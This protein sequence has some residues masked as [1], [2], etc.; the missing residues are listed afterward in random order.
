[1]DILLQDIVTNLV[2]GAVSAFIA[3]IIKTILNGFQNSGL[4]QRTEQRRASGRTIKKQ[5]LICAIAFPIFLATGIL[6]PAPLRAQTL[7]DVLLQSFKILCVLAALFL[8]LFE[9]GAFDAA[10]DYKPE[11]SF[12]VPAQES[13]RDHAEK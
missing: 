7:W 6:I 13:A 5:F 8:F 1:M 10:F 9:W 11:D 2:A 12:G 3:W 4:K